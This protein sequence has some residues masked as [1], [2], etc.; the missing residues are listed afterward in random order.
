MGID[1][2]AG[3]E[4]GHAK[5]CPKGKRQGGRLATHELNFLYEL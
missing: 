2:F 5:A 1:N 3:S 4:I